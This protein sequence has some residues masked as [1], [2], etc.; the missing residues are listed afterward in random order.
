MKQ[1]IKDITTTLTV[2]IITYL[3]FSFIAADLNFINW[4]IPVRFTFVF[5]DASI[6]GFINIKR[7]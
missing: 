7:I 5:I 2:V 1:K 4:S 6:I 3:S